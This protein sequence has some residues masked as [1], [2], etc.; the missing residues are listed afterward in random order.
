MRCLSCLAALCLALP[1]AAASPRYS[2]SANF[3]IDL[4]GDPDTRPQTWGTA[5]DVV[6]T[7]QFLVPSGYHVRLLRVYGD[8]IIWPRGRVPEGTYAGTLLGLQTIVPDIPST[9]KLANN[10]ADG[11]FLY[12]QLATGGKPERAAFDDAVAAGGLLGDDNFLYVKVAVWLNDTGLAIHMEPTWI[13][14]LQVEDA[15]G[16]PVDLG[17]ELR[18]VYSGR[19]QS[20]RK[21]SAKR[22]R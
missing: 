14:V 5:G 19:G 1:V 22:I 8:F 3:S 9:S 6:W 15:N 4:Q 17:S 13:T 20:P 12:V 18:M 16:S 11:C 7:I 2:V 21:L 10:V